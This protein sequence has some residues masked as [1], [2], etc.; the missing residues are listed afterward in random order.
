MIEKKIKILKRFSE[1]FIDYRDQDRI[2]HTIL[3][4]ISQRICGLILGY[5]DL[6]DHDQLMKIRSMIYSWNYF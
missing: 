2:E 5:E 3:E 1:C 6:N 4:M